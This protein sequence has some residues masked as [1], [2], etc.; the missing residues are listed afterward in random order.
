[1]ENLDIVIL[2]LS[3]I[4]EV[5]ILFD[6]FEAFFDVRKRMWS[7]WKIMLVSAFTVFCIFVVNTV[8][9]SYLNL[10]AFFMILWIY[11]VMLFDAGIGGRLLYLLIACSI[12]WGCEFLFMILL[13][14][15]AFIMKQNTVVEL[16]NIPWHIFTMKLLTYM[17]FTI[18]KQFSVKSKKHMDEKVFGFYLCVPVASL[19]I[20]FLTYYLGIDFNVQLQYK[21]MLC[22]YFAI[23]QFGNIFIFHAFSRYSQEL[24]NNMQQKLII[25]DKDMKLEHYNQTMHMDDKYREFIHNTSNYL[26][27]I[28]ELALNHKDKDI[29]SIIEELNIKLE[30]SSNIAY[31]NNNILN[32]VL[33]EKH[34]AAENKGISLDIYVEPGVR[35]GSASDVD[36]ITMIG[37]LVDNALEATEKCEEKHTI[38]VRIFTQN[39]GNI[40]V[41]KV[42]N[43][44][45]GNII[46][47]GMG[48]VSTKKEEGIHGVGLKSVEKTAEKCGGYLECFAENNEFIAVL[49]IA[50]A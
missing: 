35:F 47:S 46:K 36:I 22:V 41:V 25:L 29:I 24:Y 2:L 10:L 34:S 11:T 50:A 19:G 48:F 6:F 49:L 14:L 16:S 45:N 18:F 12:F 17:I 7:K 32:S 28:G 21:V 42:T 13:E 44:F 8:C 4:V 30:K 5:Y 31:C 3:C 23:M 15:P 40:C 26:K 43:S 27:T 20:M 1:M 38:F 33:S 37:N 39:D 9:I